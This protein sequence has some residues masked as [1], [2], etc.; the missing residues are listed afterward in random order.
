M[1]G[2]K[3][4]RLSELPKKSKNQQ[5][6][7]TL[8]K[9]P[10][11]VKKTAK[12]TPPRLRWENKTRLDFPFVLVRILL[13]CGAGL[14][15]IRGWGVRPG[16]GLRKSSSRSGDGNLPIS[17]YGVDRGSESD[18]ARLVDWV[19]EWGVLESWSSAL[20]VGVD[21]SHLIPLLWNPNRVCKTTSSYDIPTLSVTHVRRVS[22]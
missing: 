20:R 2:T 13:C 3:P 18:E 6:D 9:N 14:S 22:E 15:K 16:W 19:S 12:Q 5:I 21:S 11:T 7:Q 17:L 4:K 1:S 10:T 8:Q